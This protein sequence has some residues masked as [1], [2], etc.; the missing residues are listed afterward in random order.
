[1]TKH[2]DLLSDIYGINAP[3]N[4]RNLPYRITYIL[5]IILV[6]LGAIFYR[7]PLL[8][9]LL[10]LLLLLPPLSIIL[11]K[12]EINKLSIDVTP[13]SREV[14]S[15]GILN[16][17][18]SVTYTGH[19][20]LMNCMINFNY[21]NLFYPHDIPQEF[22]FPSEARKTGEFTLPFSVTK[23]GMIQISISALN[24][25]DYL[26]LYTFT[27]PLTETIE[28]PVVPHDIPAPPYPKKRVA[29]STTDGDPSEIYTTGGERSQDVRE[30][31]EYRAGDRLK[32]VHWKL[33]AKTDELMVREFEEI[34]ELYYLIIPILNKPSPD[35]NTAAND[36]LQDTLEVFLSIGKDL[37]KE[38]EPYSVA[39]FSSNDNTF[40]YKLVTTEED[41]YSALFKLYKCPIDGY[42]KAYET[43]KEKFTATTDGII[44]IQ[45]GK[46]NSKETYE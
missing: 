24:V 19:I 2:Q 8:S 21:E 14:I 30:L 25:T 45:D 27:R 32:D 6:L 38:K 40:D 28:I 34:K 17:K 10:L 39:I 16:V 11:T 15:D 35:E 46:L 29:A 18:I 41:L 37:I 1:M 31:R 36:V 5:E 20:P 33:T 3:M 44:L 43:Y 13:L 4:K 23:A 9:V 7:Q 22:V 42:Y 26:H 12:H